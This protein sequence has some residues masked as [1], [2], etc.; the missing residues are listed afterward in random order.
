MGRR[1]GEEAGAVTYPDSGPQF[2]TD[3]RYDIEQ[4][5]QPPRASVYLWRASASSQCHQVQL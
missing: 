5:V 1:L 4:V 3:L 2:G